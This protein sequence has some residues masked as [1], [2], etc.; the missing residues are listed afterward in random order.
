MFCL[1]LKCHYVA[2]C[3]VTL[4][5]KIKTTDYDRNIENR[6]PNEKKSFQSLLLKSPASDSILN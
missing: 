3:A 5:P 4:F 1:H 2:A 6:L